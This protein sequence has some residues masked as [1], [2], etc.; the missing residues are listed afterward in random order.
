LVGIF[1]VGDV[2]VDVVFF[3]VVIVV[4]VVFVDFIV[5]AAWLSVQARNWQDHSQTKPGPVP[6]LTLTGRFCCCFS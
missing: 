2:V 1:V 6:E 3:L 5:V 4:V